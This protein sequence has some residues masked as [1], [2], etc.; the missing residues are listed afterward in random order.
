MNDAELLTLLKND[1]EI[2]TDFMDDEAKAA[3]DAELSFYL[4]SA[5]EFITRE[6]IDLTESYGDASLLVMYASWLYSR[7]R[8]ESS[9]AVM[10]KMLRWNLNN[11]LFEQNNTYGNPS[12]VMPEEPV[13]DPQPDPD[14]DQED[15]DA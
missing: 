1:L 6:G 11:R 4:S 8:A 9:Y 5:R 12:A 14:N 3:K 13:P 15:G 2:V 10:P 7:R